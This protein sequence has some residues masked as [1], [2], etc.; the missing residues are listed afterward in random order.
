MQ[1]ICLTVGR[2]NK[3]EDYTP[4]TG[5]EKNYAEYLVKETLKKRYMLDTSVIVKW[6]YRKNEEDLN[7]ASI[8]YSKLQ[9]ENFIFFAPDLMV[10]EL[11]NICRAKMELTQTRISNII[12]ELYDLII[13]LGVNKKI[14]LHA[15]IIARELNISFY[16][17]IY[18]SL[19]EDLDA[20]LVTADKKLYEAAKNMNINIVTLADFAK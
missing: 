1:I 4:F 9:S 6:Y 12:A 19:T 10:Y 3:M 11:L 2:K 5:K 16:D 17:S 8:I 14:F 7:N 15:F 13:I 20:V 18:L